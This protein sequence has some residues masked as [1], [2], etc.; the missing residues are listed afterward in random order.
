M[1]VVTLR[2][3]L[4]KFVF[5]SLS[6]LA[7]AVSLLT[8]QAI[9]NDYQHELSQA[10]TAKQL[11]QRPEWRKLLHYKP[12]LLPNSYKSQVDASRF[13]L[14][15]DGKQNPQAEL[16]ATLAAFF[17]P[18][19]A[20]RDAQH[21]HPQCVFVAR[22]HWL[23]QEL[24]FDSSRLPEHTCWRFEEWMEALK[25]EGVTLIFP[26]AYL[27]S[28]ASMFGHT[29]IRIDAKD[30]TEKT[31][32]LSYA[33]NFGADT[34]ND[35]GL[36]FAVKGLLGGYPGSFSVLPYY[37]KVREYSDLENRD[38]WE[39]QL[40]LSEEETRTM[41]LHAWELR[42]IWFAYFFFDENCSYHLLSLIETARPELQL[43]DQFGAWAI[44]SDT[45]RVV[46]EAG[47]VDQIIYRPSR[48]ATLT[49]RMAGMDKPQISTIQQL[50]MAE[51]RSDDTT[52]LSM[53]VT[54]QA[55]TLELAHEYADYHQDDNET[56]LHSLLQ[57]RSALGVASPSIKV[58]GGTRPDQGHG[59]G[60]SSLILGREDSHQYQE[61]QLR[62][63]YHDLLDPSPGYSS[64]AQIAFFNLALRHDNRADTT[65]LQ[66]F[67]PVDIISLTPISDINTPMSWQFD[68]GLTRKHGQQHNRMIATVNGGAG[69]SWSPLQNS[70]LYGLINLGIDGSKRELRKGYAAG[71]GGSIGVLSEITPRWALHL[72]ARSIDY[73][74][75]EVHN[76]KRLGLEQRFSM[77]K[78]NT[79]R[80][81][82][83][84]QR[85]LADD[86]SNLN[87]SWQHYF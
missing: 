54:Q 62:P 12:G 13:F 5:V 25:P 15:E 45:V 23:K 37:L 49:H 31:R 67:T 79:L 44:P 38:I 74:A 27:N 65:R 41:L 66:H 3:S 70:T 71:F 76:E 33:I 63:A 86:F 2:H 39:Y 32:L 68:F 4:F 1:A 69:L 24:G 60:R 43:T 55:E 36:L 9:A 77:N 51:I 61:L 58:P 59:T 35:G 80:L 8:T 78:T 72:F 73:T 18:F 84:R 85:Q 34:G 30:Q 64:G 81:S 40:N 21:L 75:G 20:D 10:A 6:I 53:P 56:H 26:T 42:G 47:L 17:Q 7:I 14:A 46:D 29:L 83:T 22:Y 16:D 87:L 82:W 11:W 52:I 19:P 48:H 57:A 50:A 28:P